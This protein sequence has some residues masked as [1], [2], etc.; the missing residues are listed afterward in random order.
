M[1]TITWIALAGSL[2]WYAYTLFRYRFTFRSERNPDSSED[3]PFI[4]V[5]VPAH[6]DT[7]AL[8]RLI[9]LL[10]Q[11][12][13]PKD[14]WE[15]IVIDD[16]STPSIALEHEWIQV[17]QSETPGK[18]AALQAGIQRARGSWILTTDADCSPSPQWIE[19]MATHMKPDRDL[20]AGPVLIYEEAPSLLTRFQQWE[21]LALQ[22]LTAGSFQ[23][24]R[25]LMCNGANLAYRKARF[26]ETQP[27][28]DNLHLKSGDDTFLMLSFFQKDPK[29]LEY[30]ADPNAIVRTDPAPDVRTLF[31]QRLRW[32]TK[33]KHY[34]GAGHIHWAGLGLAV[35]NTAVVFSWL[36]VT[37]TPIVPMGM[38][39]VKGLLD[40]WLV[41]QARS[42]FSTFPGVLSWVTMLLAYPFYLVGMTVASALYPAPQNTHKAPA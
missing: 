1:S 20:L 14:R 36:F 28:A 30:V 11:Q 19:G 2:L 26:E 8:Q 33:L 38:V 16:H 10:E 40:L 12:T 5:L 24:H 31:H 39:I 6:N 42:F 9:P 17:L 21:N 22:T 3:Q 25:P 13:Y 35:G 7:A 4:T 37:T 32:S 15:L 34:S 41:W 18:K 29:R 27:Y 23:I